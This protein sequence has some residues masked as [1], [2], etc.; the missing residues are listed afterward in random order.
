MQ[1]TGK[2]FAEQAKSE[3]YTG[4]KYSTLD[5]QAFV[6]KV[7]YDSG[8]RKQNG[9]AYNWKGSNSMWRTA[10]S[11]KGTIEECKAKFGKIPLGAWVFKL[12][13]D[14]G[15]KDRGYSDKEGNACHVGI[16]VGNGQFIHSPH[17]GKVVCFADLNSDYYTDHYYGSIRVI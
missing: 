5:C 1:V 17:S 16:Y 11:W 4:I 12:K 8:C 7:L 2:K 9:S 13:F 6:E 3:E 15:E 10:L 14:G